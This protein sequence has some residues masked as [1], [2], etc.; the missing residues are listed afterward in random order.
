MVGVSS[1]GNAPAGLQQRRFEPFER[2]EI[3]QTIVRRF[4]KIVR[5]HGSRPA[6]DGPAG[7]CT[8][9]E[10][11]SA[12]NGV[13]RA[14]T[15]RPG[16][17]GP[18]PLLLESGPSLFAAMLG[19]L[20]AGRFYVPLD[21][22]LGPARLSTIFAALEADVILTDR[23]SLADAARLSADRVPVLRVEE[24]AAQGLASDPPPAGSPDDFAYVL[25]T[26]GST[27]APKGVIQSH[28]NLLHNV[29]K[30]TNGAGI[31]PDDRITLLSS[32]SFG[33]SVSDIF[34]A[35]L[36]GAAVCPFSLRG[37]GLH[38]LPSFLAEEGITV[39]HSVPSVFRTLVASLGR[40]ED[41]SKIRMVKL[42]GEPVRST[43]FDLFRRHF[44]ETSL[45]HVG[46]GATEVHV[47]RQWFADRDTPWPGASPLGYAVDGTEVVLLDGHGRPAAGEGEI[48]VVGRT[49]AV[50]YWKDPQGT[51][52]AFPA[53]PGQPGTR[54]F[55]T[56]D[57][58]RLLPDGCLLHLGRVDFRIKVRGNRVE[59]AEVE[60]ALAE[61]DGVREAAVAGR[62]DGAGGTKL[63]A[64]VVAGR[65]PGPGIGELRRALATRLPDFMVPAS[66]V[67]LGALPRTANGKVDRNAL[68]APDSERPALETEYVAPRNETEEAV[69]RVFAEVL[70]LDCVGAND[71]FFDLGGSSLLAAA[72]VTTL[73][74]LFGDGI[75]IVDLLEAPT[76]AA[77][78]ARALAGPSAALGTL[79]SLQRGGDRRPVFLVPGGAGEGPDL[80]VSVRIARRVGAEFPFFGFRSDPAP[81][82]PVEDLA[83]RYVREMRALEPNG[84]YILIGECVGGILALAMARRLCEE[85]QRV[86]LLVLLDTP[87]PS[88]RRRLRILRRLL[89]ALSGY[90]VFRRLGHHLS[91]LGS[92]DPALRR[93]YFAEKAR[94]AARAFSPA[95]RLEGHEEAQEKAAYSRML[96]SS[97]PAPWDGRVGLVVSEQGTRDG[98]AAGW[99]RL[100]PQ[101]EVVSVP[102]NHTSYKRE[103]VDRVAEALRHWLEETP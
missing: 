47:I 9:A 50:G 80:L 102:G 73:A 93:A 86:A 24:L 76:P 52:A 25:F 6:V 2:S 35:L 41:L 22:A 42:G 32:P 30:L 46:L 7:R 12:A 91:I 29:L 15:E 66:F 69:A 51:A 88:W 33:A 60:A 40:G 62:D 19:T 103:H 54:M 83:E 64:Y 39:Y 90:D 10:L 3:E 95:R 14:L 70:N 11:N 26:S 99:S 38:R 49:L 97:R 55:R 81:D 77:L 20:K 53:A 75:R 31:T 59:P 68:P 56:G 65:A 71:D 1:G 36:N 89:A 74:D 17:R 18:V 43:D 4:E 37:D 16:G 58:G 78:A 61:V 101:A 67:F 44:S 100:L 21:P 96:L 72:A 92:I 85:G 57:Y 28:R 98:I 27:G 94:V 23:A 48:A 5:A 13:A 8:Y 45:F 63:V 84:P 82:L 34:G 79:V 87:Y